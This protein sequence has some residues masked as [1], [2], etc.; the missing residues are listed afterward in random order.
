MA[1]FL[2]IIR[3]VLTLTPAVIELVK[4]V[5]AALPQT[6]QGA[7]KLALVRSTLQ[8]AFDVGDSAVATFDQVWP[9]LDKTITAVVGTLNATG[10]FKKEKSIA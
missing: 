8:A 3:L 5:E 2:A 1:N 6:G 7:Q 4:A 9:A 10:V